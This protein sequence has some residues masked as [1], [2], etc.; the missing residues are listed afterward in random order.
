MVAYTKYSKL[1]TGVRTKRQRVA[2]IGIQERGCTNVLAS[3]KVCGASGRTAVMRPWKKL[4]TPAAAVALLASSWL[5]IPCAAADAL[6]R[7][8]STSI[9]TVSAAP[10][11]QNGFPFM[12]STLN[13]ASTGYVEQEFFLSGMAQAYIPVTP[14]PLKRDGRWSVMPNPGVTAPYTTRILVRRP[15]SAERFNGTVI[16]EWFN[17]SSGFDAPSD[18]LYMHDE[19]MREG[20]AY[21]GVTAQFVGVQALVGWE[22]GP[23][24]RYASLFHPGES[25]AYDIFAQ[26]GLIVTQSRGGDPRLLGNLTSRVQ[27]VLAAGFS[28]SA[29]WLTTYV[30]AIHRISPVY[31]GFLIHDAGFDE[32]LSLD[33]ASLYGDPIPPGVPATPFINTPYP[34]QL[35]SDQNVPTLI[36]LSEFG[37]SD[38]GNVA[39]RSFH[40]QPD[41]PQIR[42][43]ELAGATH[44]ERGWFQEFAAD[45]AKTLPGFA[46]TPCYGPPGIPSIIHGQAA[47]AALNVLNNWASDEAAPPSAP[48]I[49]LVVPTPPGKFSV[50]V[51]FNRDPATNLAIGGIRLPA[52]AV[53]TAT[54][55]GNRSDLERRT[56]GPG[57][58]CSFTGSFD[59]WNHD[60]DSWDGQS[61]LDPS[62]TP[63]PDLQLLYLTHD[64]YV[65]H[66]AAAAWQSIEDG[67]LRPIDGV[68]IVIDAAKSHVP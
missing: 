68:E 5:S 20:Y 23:D 22:S 29:A 56:L 44:L 45:A 54:L 26:A 3:I 42:V 16:V 35:R 62:P 43:W 27:T 52:V 63:E 14:N 25:F 53:P 50:P 61:G 8:S 6:S 21:V 38:R 60:S 10:K 28:Q 36:V 4:I 51:L 58:Q 66:V 39:G 31:G 57:P 17:E 18:W 64:N 41:S 37:L 49:S 46:L 32:P 59:R 11:G 7:N 34:M 33:V 19:I 67:Y 12:A 65:E 13:L 1:P 9:P 30:N 48:R 47:R 55:N 2:R 24:A 40:L 15:I